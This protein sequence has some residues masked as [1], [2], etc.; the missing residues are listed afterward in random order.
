MRKE[1][2]GAGNLARFDYWYT[3]LKAHKM[4]ANFASELNQY[5]VK[6]NT[7]KL[8]EAAE[9]RSN[10]ARLWEK[11]M[12]L[13]VQKVY[14]EVDLGVILKLDWRTW[15]NWVEGK[16]DK[17]FL[18]AGGIL[19]NDK[20][21]SQ[22]YAGDKFITCIPLLTNMKSNEELNIKALIMGEVNKPELHF[23][24]LGENTFTT[25]DMN[26]QARGVFRGIIPEQE[27]DFEW[28]VTA[29]T[30]LGDAVFSATAD[31]S[32]QEKM[33]HTVVVTE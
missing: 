18:K 8:R 28:Y 30:S 23:R 16:Y 27:D 10:L 5:E 15:K 21:P 25:I 12:S 29:Q 1:I 13:K 17:N 22:E 11:I 14:D 20:D 32:L 26:H 2:E 6:T 3:A 31:E 7:G 19:P 33:Y 9:H 4:M 24:V